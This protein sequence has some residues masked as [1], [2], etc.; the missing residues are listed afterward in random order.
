MSGNKKLDQYAYV[1]ILK[2]DSNAT[3]YDASADNFA[4][5]TGLLYSSGKMSEKSSAKLDRLLA[6][7]KQHNKHNDNKDNKK[8]GAEDEDK[9][10]SIEGS[11]VEVEKSV[12]SKSTETTDSESSK[13]DTNELKLSKE[14]EN[15][16]IKKIEDEYTDKRTRS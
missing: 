8:Q 12:D 5:S 13:S 1:K 4:I 16:I 14:E 7:I 3:N 15:A 2:S 9:K 6:G 11:K 10:Q